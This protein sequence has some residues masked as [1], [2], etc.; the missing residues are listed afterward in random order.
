MLHKVEL[1]KGP[2]IRMLL[3]QQLA[4]LIRSCEEGIQTLASAKKHKKDPLKSAHKEWVNNRKEYDPLE[5]RK[6]LAEETP[7][8][9]IVIQALS[10]SMGHDLERTFAEQEL[11]DLDIA[12]DLTTRENPALFLRYQLQERDEKALALLSSIKV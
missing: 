4:P 2:I 11:L 6:I 9:R 12:A 1:L 7:T 8:D 10:L 5:L 3:R